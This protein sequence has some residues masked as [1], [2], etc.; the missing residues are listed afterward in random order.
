MGK[1]Q[2]LLLIMLDNVQVYGLAASKVGN[3]GTC[4][5]PANTDDNLKRKK[6]NKMK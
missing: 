6:Q 3:K 2:W 5:N 1:H 4:K